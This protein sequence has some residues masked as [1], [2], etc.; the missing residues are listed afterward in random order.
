VGE[1]AYRL[2]LHEELGSIHPTFH[3]SH[4]RKCLED[5]DTRVPISEIE[6]EDSL[7]YV[8]E[9][10]AIL[11][12]KEKRLRNITILLVKVQWRHR[13]GSEATWETEEE[14]RELYP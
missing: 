13:R 10:I 7:S 2:E 3:V 12:R 4:L 9:P 6:V 5:E 14:M 1:V 11:E 8:E